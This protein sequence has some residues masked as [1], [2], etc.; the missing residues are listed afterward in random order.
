MSAVVGA[1][2]ADA[3]GTRIPV[4]HK[5]AVRARFLAQLPQDLPAVLTV[6]TAGASAIMSEREGGA[7]ALAVAEL[8]VGAWVLF[9]IAAEARHAF[10]RHGV[11]G[12][13]AGARGASWISVPGIA[14]AALGYVEVWHH[15]R[16]RGHFKLVSPYMLGATAT[17]FLAIGGRRLIQSRF[18]N[19]RPHLLVT[20]TA[21][22]YRGSRR[23]RWTTAWDDVAAVEHGSGELTLRL[24]NGGAHVLR[25]DDHLDG[26]DLIAAARAAVATHAPP[27]FAV[28][29][30]AASLNRS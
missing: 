27:R 23:R 5:K 18:R 15:T 12:A 24:R 26:G 14:A 7:L 29:S 16:E 10:G 21:V 1:A 30:G 20:P 8:L 13:T 4:Q 25:A 11:H 17:L 3:G 6:L 2:A 22:T 19:R 9:T 28:S